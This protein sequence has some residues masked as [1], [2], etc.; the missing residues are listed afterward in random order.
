MPSKEEYERLLKLFSIEERPAIIQSRYS[1]KIIRSNCIWALSSLAIINYEYFGIFDDI[2]C[3]F[4]SEDVCSTP[5][6][7]LLND[8]AVAKLKNHLGLAN[9]DTIFSSISNRSGC[10][11]CDKLRELINSETFKILAQTNSSEE[12]SVIS[13][14]LTG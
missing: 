2:V 3:S 12:P 1:R 8:A 11:I 5:K 9:A 14:K 10:S 4:T 13:L 6:A 7:E